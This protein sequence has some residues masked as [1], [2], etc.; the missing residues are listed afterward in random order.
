MTN[1]S[2]LWQ[3]GNGNDEVCWWSPYCAQNLTER[4]YWCWWWRCQRRRQWCWWYSM[5]L[6]CYLTS[7]STPPKHSITASACC[8]DQLRQLPNK[9]SSSSPQNTKW[10]TLCE[11]L[12]KQLFYFNEYLFPV[13]KKR[14]KKNSKSSQD[15]EDN[16]CNKACKVYLWLRKKLNTIKKKILTYVSR[17][18]KIL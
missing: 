10:W 12:C 11:Q 18:V 1:E 3:D 17:W 4:W 7:V 14:I 8:L 16:I 9:S 13:Q 2:H 15:I 6:K 5:T